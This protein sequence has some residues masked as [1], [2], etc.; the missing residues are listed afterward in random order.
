MALRCRD[1]RPR[2]PAVPGSVVRSV[3]GVPEVAS[4]P[5]DGFEVVTL[6]RRLPALGGSHMWSAESEESA[7][8]FVLRPSCSL[9]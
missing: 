3:D 8:E 7:A 6:D 2:L 9:R 4:A 5:V 1:G